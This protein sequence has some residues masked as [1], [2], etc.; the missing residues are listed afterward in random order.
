MKSRR[1][2][3]PSL[4]ICWWSF[5]VALVLGMIAVVIWLSLIPKKPKFT[6]VDLYI[7]TLNTS[8]GNSSNYEGIIQNT[9]LILIL[10]VS[11]PNKGIAVFYSDMN[12][13]LFHRGGDS[14]GKQAVPG[15]Y[16][17]HKSS[18]SCNVTTGADQKQLWR[19]DAGRVLDLRMRLEAAVRF[20]IIWWK[21]RHHRMDFEAFVVVDPRGKMQGQR[22]TRLIQ[23]FI[24]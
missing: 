17:G 22:N 18:L 2:S 8:T 5:Q 7:P 10:Q 1:I 23:K 24:N 11:N 20:K 9:S 16:Q 14:I 3:K 12:I 19:G 6:I 4:A 15:F 21:T 13:S